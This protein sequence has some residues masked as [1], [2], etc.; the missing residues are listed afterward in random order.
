MLED[1]KDSAKHKALAY[2][3]YRGVRLLGTFF[4][5]WLKERKKED[6]P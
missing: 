2:T 5:N 6:L 4:Y 1:A 3:Y